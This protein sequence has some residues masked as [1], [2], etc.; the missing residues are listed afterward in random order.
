MFLISS[1]F[2]MICMLWMAARI[3]K[4][5]PILAIVSFLFLPAAVIPLIQNWGDEESDIKVPFFLALASSV[6]TV[7]S[8][9][10]FAK[11]AQEEQESFL[12]IVRLFA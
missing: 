5:S 8:M 3:W 12:S 6:Y 4:S 7:Y 11:S 2:T 1:L 10:S 9:M